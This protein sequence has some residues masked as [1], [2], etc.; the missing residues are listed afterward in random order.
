MTKGNIQIHSC[1]GNFLHKLTTEWLCQTAW[2]SHPQTTGK[3]VATESHHKRW[4]ISE[5]YSKRTPGNNHYLQQ[6]KF[7]LDVKN[8][9]FTVLTLSK[10]KQ[11]SRLPRERAQ[12]P[13]SEISKIYVNKAPTYLWSCPCFEHEAGQGDFQRSTPILVFYDY[14]LEKPPE[15]RE[16]PFVQ[17]LSGCWLKLAQKVFI[18][19]FDKSQQ[20]TQYG[21]K[22]PEAPTEDVIFKGTSL[23][24]N[25]K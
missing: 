15:D 5:T 7:V 3:P 2:R 10:V 24:T 20:S 17:S 18:R 8:K 23:A 16:D 11:W 13:S 4:G 1:F 6:Q 25:L 12:P 19:K 14:F 22:L 21:H 9:F